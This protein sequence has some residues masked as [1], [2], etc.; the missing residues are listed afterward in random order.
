LPNF[1]SNMG[2]A[3]RG[4]H[5]GMTQGLLATMV[6]HT[7]PAQ[8]RGTASGFFNL[9]SGVVTLVSSVIAGALWDRTGAAATFYAGAGFCVL[10]IALCS[11]GRQRRLRV[12][13]SARF[14]AMRKLRLPFVF[15]VRT[16]LLK[17]GPTT[18]IDGA[19]TRRALFFTNSFGT[20][21][22]QPLCNKQI[23]G[24]HQ[25]VYRSRLAHESSPAAWFIRWF[26]HCGQHDDRYPGEGRLVFET[27]A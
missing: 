13:E 19:P 21:R 2:V 23:N 4:L 16:G 11:C 12:A 27:A 20:R 25:Q 26:R 14:Q 10:T 1:L 22:S 18:G 15:G 5:M 9:L 7:A 3:L 24:V 8:L 17:S 6:A